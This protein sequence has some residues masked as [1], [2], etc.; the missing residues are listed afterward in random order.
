M[1]D[2]AIEV[3]TGERVF[4]KAIKSFLEVFLEICDVCEPVSQGLRV[5]GPFGT[6][7]IVDVLF[8]IFYLLL[9]SYHLYETVNLT[10]FYQ[11][12]LLMI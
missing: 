1:L 12:F 4:N 11:L 5:L 2:L 10:N 9:V 8:L 3:V 7:L 6:K